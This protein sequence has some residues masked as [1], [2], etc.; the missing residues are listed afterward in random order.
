[1]AG[2]IDLDLDGQ[3][4][5]ADHGARRDFREHT[6]PPPFR[7]HGETHIRWCGGVHLSQGLLPAKN[8]KGYIPL[9]KPQ[10][11]GAQRA[12]SRPVAQRVP[13]VLDHGRLARRLPGDTDDVE[14]AV[15]AVEPAG[16]EIGPGQGPK[17]SPLAGINAL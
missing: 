10:F 16:I 11:T 12:C 6:A 15:D 4:V 17:L 5:D 8:L 14:T 2:H 1:A 9:Y 7:D 3:R 13:H